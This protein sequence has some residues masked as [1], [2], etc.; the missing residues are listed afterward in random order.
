MARR[1]R[2]ACLVLLLCAAALPLRQAAELVEGL[3]EAEA[4][5][6]KGLE[7]AAPV[8]SDVIAQ[9]GAAVLARCV[10]LRFRSC[11]RPGLAPGGRQPA[12]VRRASRT[13]PTQLRTAPCARSGD[14]DVDTTGSCKADI[15]HFCENTKPGEGRLAACL[16]NQQEAEAAGT[17]TGRKLAPECAT[18]LRQYKIDRCG[19]HGQGCHQLLPVTQRLTPAAPRVHSAEN[20]NK[21]LQLAVAC[22]ED[23]DKFCNSS[24]LFPE[25]GA[26]LTCLR[27]AVHAP[28]VVLPA[29]RTVMRTPRLGAHLLTPAPRPAA[30]RSRTS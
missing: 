29:L 1:A 9:A 15:A 2:R 8:I 13:R 3:A 23:A 17:A 20:I 18:E 10:G 28:R 6:T 21:D 5:Q 4:A 25:P 7:P 11:T 22:K 27:C 14:G 30:G 12:S 16:T 26:V 24:N 19:Q